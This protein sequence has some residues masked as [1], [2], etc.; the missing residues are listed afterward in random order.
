MAEK[1]SEKVE[2]KAPVS[3]AKTAAKPKAADKAAAKKTAPALSVDQLE[4]EIRAQAQ[5]VYENRQAKGLAGDE[6]S[7]WLEAEVV[8][9]KKYKL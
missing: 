8:I 2:K 1:K 4:K 3:K 5:K 9:K 6:L 7:D